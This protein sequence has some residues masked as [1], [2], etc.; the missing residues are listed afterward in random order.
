MAFSPRKDSD[1][2]MFLHRHPSSQ[3]MHEESEDQ[4]LTSDCT[5][6]ILLRLRMPRLTRVFDVHKCHSVVFVMLR[7]VSILVDITIDI[8]ISVLENLICLVCLVCGQVDMITVF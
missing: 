2:Y 4:H 7:L 6:N 5:A 1:L 3:I 8:L